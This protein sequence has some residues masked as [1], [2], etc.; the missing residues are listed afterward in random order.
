MVVV[1]MKANGSVC[2]RFIMVGG[3]KFSLQRIHIVDK[4]LL[5]QFRLKEENTAKCGQ[6]NSFRPS[7]A[8]IAEQF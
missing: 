4:I 7:S 8:L 1:G 5:R 2:D 3:R 6:L